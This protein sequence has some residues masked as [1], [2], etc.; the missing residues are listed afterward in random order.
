MDFPN[1]VL[2]DGDKKIQF[3]QNKDISEIHRLDVK[4]IFRK[5]F[6]NCL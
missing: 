3:N 6:V 2:K 4:F 5:K 1:A